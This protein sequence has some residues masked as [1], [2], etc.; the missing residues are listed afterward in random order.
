MVNRRDRTIQDFG[1][2]WRI[3]GSAEEDYWTSGRRLGNIFATG[4]PQFFSKR[5]SWMWG[6]AQD[7]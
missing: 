5:F 2:Q 7:T 1:N 6:L 3:H 4:I